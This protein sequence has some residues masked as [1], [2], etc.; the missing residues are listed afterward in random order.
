VTSSAIS[1]ALQRALAQRAGR[2]ADMR[3]AWPGD[4]RLLRHQGGQAA[5]ETMFAI[6][7]LVLLILVIAQLFVISD[8]AMGVV[9][10]V[11]YRATRDAHALDGASTFRFLEETYSKDV[12]ALPGMEMALRH[13]DQGGTPTSYSVERR[14]QV[15]AGSFMNAGLNKF[16]ID[17]DGMPRGTSGA[18]AT[19]MSQF[20]GY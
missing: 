1:R 15:A 14:V 18:R 9:G 20:V 6:T 11:H 3:P 10:G 12:Q 5:V 4:R 8:L 19:T 13:W 16:V 7:V 17:G 2:L